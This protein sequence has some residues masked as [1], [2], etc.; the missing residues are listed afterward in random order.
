MPE[1]YCITLRWVLQL[2]QKL[3]VKTIC[4]AITDVFRIIVKA[5]RIA[6]KALELAVYHP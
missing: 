3:D 4:S 1:N 6:D 5:T 2:V